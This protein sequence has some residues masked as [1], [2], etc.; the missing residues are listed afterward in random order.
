MI[1]RA[2]ER[3]PDA[4][5]VAMRR[6]TYDRLLTG[7]YEAA[8]VSVPDSGSGVVVTEIMG[9]TLWIPFMAGNSPLGPKAFTAFMRKMMAQYEDM[10]RKAGCNEIRICGRDW[11]WV[12]PD[13]ER[14]GDMPNELR[15]KL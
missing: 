2:I 9:R 7:Q 1:G 13:W 3:T 5:P 6:E 15:K 4:D 10:A 14:D 12:F 11:S 8:V